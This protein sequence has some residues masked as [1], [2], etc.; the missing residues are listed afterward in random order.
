[1]IWNLRNVSE[2]GDSSVLTEI[3]SD[4]RFGGST[5]SDFVASS[6]IG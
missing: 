6:I 5:G 3:K 1:M 2:T 4:I